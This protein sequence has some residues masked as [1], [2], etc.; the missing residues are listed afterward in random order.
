MFNKIKQDVRDAESS[1]TGMPVPSID[2]PFTFAPEALS[3]QLLAELPSIRLP[4][5]TSLY[6]AVCAFWPD[7]HPEATPPK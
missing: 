3:Y 2:H 7:E 1:D 5:P 4:V 6:V